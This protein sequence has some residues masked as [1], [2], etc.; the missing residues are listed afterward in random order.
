M[1]KHP[2]TGW[3][4]PVI[5]NG[6]TGEVIDPDAMGL[7]IESLK[8]MLPDVSVVDASATNYLGT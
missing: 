4:T 3:P 8:K 2:I 6:K 7:S 5:M 1:S